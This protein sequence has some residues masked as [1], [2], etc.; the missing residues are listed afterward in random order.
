MVEL[1][2]DKVK[3]NEIEMKVGNDSG[4]WKGRDRIEIQSERNE[5][6]S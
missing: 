1:V 6:E 3:L 2:K 5:I 4:W